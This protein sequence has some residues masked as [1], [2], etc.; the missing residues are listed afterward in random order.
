V[1]EN[2]RGDA[3]GIYFCEPKSF[4]AANLV[5]AAFAH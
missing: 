1:H 3:A 5:N 4:G 2:P